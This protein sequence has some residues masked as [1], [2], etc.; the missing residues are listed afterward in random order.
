MPLEPLSLYADEQAG[1]G[2]GS[3]CCCCCEQSF[4]RPL[5][6]LYLLR[7]HR[8]HISFL[9]LD[10]KFPNLKQSFSARQVQHSLSHTELVRAHAKAAATSTTIERTVSTQLSTFD[11][12]GCAWLSGDGAAVFHLCEYRPAPSAIRHSF[13]HSFIHLSAFSSRQLT[14]RFS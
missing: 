7:I 5:Q 1:G 8:R 4:P 10:H 13:I 2:Q 3:C 6:V 12:R 9:L 11:N 14:F